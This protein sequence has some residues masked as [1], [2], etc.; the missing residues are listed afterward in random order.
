MTPSK[1]KNLQWS[2]V[3][4]IKA[5]SSGEKKVNSS[6]LIVCLHEWKKHDG[7][8]DRD[9]EH[10]I[11]LSHGEMGRRS[12]AYHRWCMT[13]SPIIRL[14]HTNKHTHSHLTYHE[15][16]TSLWAHPRTTMEW[17]HTA[18]ERTYTHT[19]I[20]PC[21]TDSTS[22]NHGL[23]PAR[24]KHCWTHLRDPDHCSALSPS[25]SSLQTSLM[26]PIIQTTQW[27]YDNTL[28]EKNSEQSQQ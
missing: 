19:L 18:R 26:N 23:Q 10:A 9:K 21:S 28:I 8:I 25:T 4:C 27:L 3:L 6:G 2:L 16:G 5:E 14:L 7:K 17:M 1:C 15:S 24:T 12:A 22:N 11:N 20:Q 13:S